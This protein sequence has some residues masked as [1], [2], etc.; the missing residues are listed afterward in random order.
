VNGP[1]AEAGKSGATIFLVAGEPSGDRLG[2]AL[3]AALSRRS[4]GLRFVGVGGDEMAGQGL[5]S[6]FPMAELSL[7]GFLEVLP[8]VPRLARRL[9]ETTEAV[10]AER[11]QLLVTIDAPGFNMRLIRRVAGSGIPI[12]HYVAP[13]IWAWRPG[14]VRQLVGRVDRLLA[15]LPFEPPLFTAAGVPCDYVGHPALE[16]DAGSRDPAAFR[17]RHGVDPGAPLLCLLPGSR[18]YEIDRL[19]PVF[20]EAV[21]T[22]RA[23]E[24]R[25][26]VVLPTLPA[27]APR[28]EALVANWTPRPRLLL[29]AADR[30]DAFAAADLALAASGTVILELARFAVP[31]VLAYRG[32][33]LSAA[34]LRRLA[35]VRHAGLVNLLLD[36]AVIPEFLQENCRPA[37]IAAALL[38][39]LRDP[40]LRER[41]RAGQREAIQRLGAERPSERAAEVLFRLLDERG[42]RPVA[43]DPAAGLG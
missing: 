13:A 36:R 37:P 2:G 21:A 25:L 17:A 16:T 24:P 14:R 11:P 12:A 41:Q 33:P 19:L 35:R 7:M 10:L 5:R 27:I 3:M 8:H 9:R 4:P 32:N 34:I 31:T 26:A 40:A 1:E 30:Y 29:T 38:T 18:R 28:V 15:L 42:S 23:A 39:L 20:G 22:L 6:L 43:P